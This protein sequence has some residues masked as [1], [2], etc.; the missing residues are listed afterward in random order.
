MIAF[1]HVAKTGGKSVE[2][3]LQSHFGATYC[4]AV[5][6]PGAADDPQRRR[7][8]IP[9]YGPEELRRIADLHPGL[10][11]LG[12]HQVAL[13]SGCAEVWPDAVH[14]LFLR[15]PLK[16]GASHYQYHVRN[17]DYT[18]LIGKPHYS[19]DEWVEWPVHHDH[20]IKML[21]PTVETADAVRR[22]QA[23]NVF[24]GLTERFD[25]SLVLFRGLFS[26]GLNIA[27]TRANSAADNS[28]AGSL[29]DDPR[30]REQISAM[31]AREFDLYTFAAGDLWEQYRKAYGPGLAA[32]VA[33]F[34]EHRH[35]VNRLNILRFKLHHRLVFAPRA[36]RLPR[37]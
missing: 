27:Y 20:Q 2:T 11:S 28:L 29:L 25:E 12:G 13:W 32:D 24:V 36:A 5:D 30:R 37:R 10:R 4:E 14:L 16:R 21:S 33:A 17:D 1:V 15:E 22:I 19:W 34:R 3:A 7:F 26:P 18:H 8:H 31:Y 9:K 35:A 23:G 6:L